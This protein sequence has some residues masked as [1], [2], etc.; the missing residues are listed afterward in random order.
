MRTHTLTILAL[1]LLRS[2]AVRADAKADAEAAF[3]D[4]R[5]LAREGNHAAACPRFE[6]SYRA[7][8]A[9]GALLHLADCH[10]RIG[11]TASAW[12]EFR[13]A[14]EMARVRVDSREQAARAHLAALEP[15]L[16]R[17]RVAVLEPR[18]PGLVVRRGPRE[19]MDE[20]G[21]A[22][23]VDPGEYLIEASAPG[24][25]TWTVTV[26]VE[27]EGRTVEVTV[28][29]LVEPT[30]REPSAWTCSP[31]TSVP[32]HPPEPAPAEPAGARLPEH[33]FWSARRVLA[34]AAGGA[35]VVSLGAGLYVG[36]RARSLWD[37]SRDHCRAGNVCD[38]DG[39]A[40]IDRA[41]RRAIAADVLVGAGAAAIAAGVALWMLSPGSPDGEGDQHG[42]VVV[43]AIGVDSV[44]ASLRGS[45]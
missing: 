3:Q 24:C 41:G 42:V 36:S 20:L 12:A 16:V 35:G 6:A 8:P 25:R 40:L 23:P 10:E 14:A 1:L 18:P 44:G 29:P 22:V 4:G 11:R 19:L 9:L 2:G 15:R 17:L 39:R 37:D 30:A 5:R 34:A 28:P 26:R 13:E 38:R 31:R 32:H 21:R 45:F 7:E 43:P 33:R 27:G